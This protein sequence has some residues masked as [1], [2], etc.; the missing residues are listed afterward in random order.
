MDNNRLVSVIVRTKDRPRMLVKALQ[1]ITGQTYRPI[2]VVLVNDGGCALDMEEIKVILGDC[3]CIYIALEHNRGR[4]HAGNVGLTNAS[5]DYI[6]FL[7]D[8][9]DLLPVHLQT[10]VTFLERSDFYTA[11]SDCE[12]VHKQYN[13]EKQEFI[14]A[15]TYVFYSEDFNYDTLLMENYI[16]IHCLLFKRG[17][18]D[19]STFDESFELFED[20]DL[21]IRLASK[22]PFHH[23]KKTT[24]HY[25]NWDKFSQITNV[26]EKI[27]TEAYFKVVKKHRAR[28]T[29][30]V[31]R[32]YGLVGNRRKCISVEANKISANEVSKN[33]EL[34]QRIAK[35]EEVNRQ[36]HDNLRQLVALQANKEV[37]RPLRLFL[38]AQKE[39]T[40]PELPFSKV[41][42]TYLELIF[43]FVE[44]MEHL[45]GE[46]YKTVVNAFMAL[47]PRITELEQFNVNASTSVLWKLAQ[48]Y[49]ALRDRIVLSFSKK[50][51]NHIGTVWYFIHHYN[52]SLVSS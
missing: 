25:N 44:N 40:K 41:M 20:W 13:I 29:E 26:G 15:Y 50:I 31:I 28:I 36:L 42:L 21:L 18:I 52:A 27:K 16:P 51:E 11:Y 32:N 8:D 9:D 5:G 17:A 33:N 7:D 3:R 48:R 19:G 47:I 1:S 37:I 2:E 49:Y 34:K 45:P 4:A 35:L 24:A 6:G 22:H 38:Q 12:I 10:L 23:I 39:Q 14:D 46:D 30:E 43:A